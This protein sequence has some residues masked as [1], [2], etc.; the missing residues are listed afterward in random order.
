M[1]T[2]NLTAVYRDG[3]H[4]VAQYGQWDGY[5]EGLG[6]TLLGMLTGDFIE[7][8]S[9]SLSK[10]RFIDDVKDKDFIESYNNNAPE[11]SNDP[12][13]RTTEQKEWFR[14][15]ASRDLSSKLLTNIIESTEEEILLFDKIE[16]AKDG[17]FC[18][19]AYVI[20]LDSREFEV[21]KGFNRTTHSGERFST[22]MVDDQGYAPVKLV[23]KYSFDDLPSADEFLSDF[24]VNEE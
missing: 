5:P 20:D 18:E 17:L 12:D 10:V 16:F 13:N 24:E 19:W 7:S 21:Y 8:L 22:G 11:W 14:K 15:F 4:K 1:G 9:S 6:V 2:R 3:V 23:K